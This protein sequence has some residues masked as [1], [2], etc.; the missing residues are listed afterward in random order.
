MGGTLAS[1]QLLA[2]SIGASVQRPLIPGSVNGE[3]AENLMAAE[4]VVVLQWCQRRQQRGTSPWSS[5]PPRASALRCPC[6]MAPAR[7]GA[8]KVMLLE[9]AASPSGGA[10]ELAPAVVKPM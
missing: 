4:A 10:R 9:D 7:L 6:S 8:V 5:G 3:T 1:S 2:N